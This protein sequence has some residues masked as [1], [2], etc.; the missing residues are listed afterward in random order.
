MEGG[1]R[2]RYRGF[3]LGL[4]EEN[5]NQ[6]FGLTL[7]HILFFFFSFL[8]TTAMCSRFQAEP[9]KHK[10]SAMGCEKCWTFLSVITELFPLQKAWSILDYFGDLLSS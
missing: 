1:C 6:E 3:D 5:L 9:L 7:P 10:H 8:P 4:T 2:V